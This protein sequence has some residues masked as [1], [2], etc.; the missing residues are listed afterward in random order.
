MPLG[1]LGVIFE[2]RPNVTIDISALAIKTGN[3]AIMRGGRESLRTN[4]V[5]ADMV[6]EACAATGLPADTIRRSP[7]PSGRW[8]PLSWRWTTSS[9]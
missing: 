3:A 5:L 4:I 8:C 6:G 1:V 2:S 7:L 9:T